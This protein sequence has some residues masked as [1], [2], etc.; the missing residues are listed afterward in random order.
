MKFLKDGAG[1]IPIRAMF[2]VDVVFLLVFIYLIMGS[3][4]PLFGMVSLSF[5]FLVGVGVLTY[6]RSDKE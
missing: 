3:S 2:I 1:K 4:N 6:E 5:G